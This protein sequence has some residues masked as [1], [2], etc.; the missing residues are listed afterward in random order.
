MDIEKLTIAD[1]E[2]LKAAIAASPPKSIPP[3]GPLFARMTADT[4]HADI[5]NLKL[6]CRKLKAAYDAYYQSDDSDHPDGILDAVEKVMEAMSDIDAQESRDI[7]GE[8]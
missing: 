7:G 2:R 1:I 8:G 3:L 5:E 4:T 6:A